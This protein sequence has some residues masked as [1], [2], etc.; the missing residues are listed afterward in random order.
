MLTNRTRAK[1]RA[2]LEKICDK[3]CNYKST[4]SSTRDSMLENTQKDKTRQL[5]MGAKLLPPRYRMLLTS[6]N[7]S[8]GLNAVKC[9]CVLLGQQQT[10]LRL[11]VA[12]QLGNNDM[13]A[14][15]SVRYLVRT[16]RVN[17][18]SFAHDFSPSYSLPGRMAR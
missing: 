7:A 11:P 17:R 13:R 10:A 2:Y 1:A 6:M 14:L 8:N 9:F 3:R 18:H 12:C 5:K 4:M 16:A 15:E